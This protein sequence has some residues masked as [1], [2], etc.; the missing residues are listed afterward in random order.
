M[1]QT[2]SSSNYLK[3]LFDN[4]SESLQHI[5]SLY[6]KLAQLKRVNLS[7]KFNPKFIEREVFLRN[8]KNRFRHL[9]NIAKLV[10]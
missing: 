7:S 5:D 6:A 9:L 10:G 3:I 8:F 1:K 2:N 4:K